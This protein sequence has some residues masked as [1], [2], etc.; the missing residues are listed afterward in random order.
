MSTTFSSPIVDLTRG[1]KTAS[2]TSRE[3]SWTACRRRRCASWT[4]DASERLQSRLN[5]SPPAFPEPLRSRRPWRS[6]PTA[7]VQPPS[8]RAGPPQPL[9]L[10]APA[11]PLCCPGHAGRAVGR[12][13]GWG[14]FASGWGWG[15]AAGVVAQ[16]YCLFFLFARG[17]I[18]YICAMSVRSKGQASEVRDR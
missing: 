17:D 10:R 14:V 4:I 12:G 7:P 2:K 13:R 6:Y 15:R 8:S 1:F 11:G 5:P 18:W 16:K 9:A 3:V